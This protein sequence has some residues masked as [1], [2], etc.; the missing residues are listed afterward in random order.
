MKDENAP[1]KGGIEP[2]FF[3]YTIY[4]K[5]Q[6]VNINRIEYLKYLKHLME[7]KRMIKSPESRAAARRGRDYIL[8]QKLK[9]YQ[10]GF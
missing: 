2:T 7:P 8:R 6:I 10:G 9:L 1:S 4:L 3:R 5:N